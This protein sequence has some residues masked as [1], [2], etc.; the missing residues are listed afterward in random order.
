MDLSMNSMLTVRSVCGALRP[1]SMA[2]GSRCCCCSYCDE[3]PWG[4]LLRGDTSNKPL[5]WK[6]HHLS[7]ACVLESLPATQGQ[8]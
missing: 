6:G 5:E 1:K 7:P 8:R 3:G 4:E 2:S